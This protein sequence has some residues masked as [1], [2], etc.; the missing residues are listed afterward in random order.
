VQV[1]EGYQGWLSAYYEYAAF[2]RAHLIHYLS[3]GRK[4]SE[5]QIHLEREDNIHE[6]HKQGWGVLFTQ[7]SSNLVACASM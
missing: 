1:G 4:I 2:N 3:N 5:A 6:R 7:L